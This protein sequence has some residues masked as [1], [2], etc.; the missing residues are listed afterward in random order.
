MDSSDTFVSQLPRK[1][2]D[3]LMCDFYVLFLFVIGGQF[4]LFQVDID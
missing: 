4:L 2:W 3:T 1:L